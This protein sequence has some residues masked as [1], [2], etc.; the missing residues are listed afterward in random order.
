MSLSLE[1]I[2]TL[3]ASTMSVSQA[4]YTVHLSVLLSV[5]CLGVVFVGSWYLQSSLMELNTLV[6]D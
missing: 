4:T 6:M 1:L 5:I 2:Q 3:L